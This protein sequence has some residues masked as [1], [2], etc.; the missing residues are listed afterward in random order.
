MAAAFGSSLMTF[1]PA[2]GRQSFTHV[3]TLLKR[4]VANIWAGRVH[5]VYW[6][7]EYYNTTPFQVRRKK[8]PSQFS[9]ASAVNRDLLI[10][11]E[12]GRTVVSQQRKMLGL[13]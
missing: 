11:V 1:Q 13:Q 12:L 6:V 9:F 4:R 8:I 7:L 5:M 10:M 2:G 3:A